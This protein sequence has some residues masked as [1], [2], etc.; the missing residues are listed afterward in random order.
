MAEIVI[1]TDS[2]DEILGELFLRMRKE[3]K[4]RRRPDHFHEYDECE[5]FVRFRLTKDTVL[6]ILDLIND[7][8]EYM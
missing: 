8:L 4:V 5:F 1:E 7:Q 2:D 3:R 6:R